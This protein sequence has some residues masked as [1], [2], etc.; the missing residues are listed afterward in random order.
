[1]S[2]CTKFDFQYTDAECI[3]RTFSK[4]KLNIENVRV[5]TD[6]NLKWR[7]DE[8]PDFRSYVPARSALGA[9]KDGFNIFMEDMGKYY[10]L[11][12]E[13]HDMDSVEKQY[14]TALSEQFRKTYLHEVAEVFVSNMTARGTNCMLDESKDGL[15][16]RFGTMYEK[17]IFIKFENGRVVEEVHGV[18]GENCASLTEA[19]ENMLSSEDVDLNT[20]WTEEY[21]ED[22]DNG[23]NIYNMEKF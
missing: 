14:A 22:P 7:V 8:Y 20:E 6:G 23:L 12:V 13:K 4:L 10:E 15:A 2:H 18:K 19:L 1:M 16:V 9:K 11:S 21:Y 3:R 5:R 17:S